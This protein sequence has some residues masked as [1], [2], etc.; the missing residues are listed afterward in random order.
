MQHGLNVEEMKRELQS[1]E[2]EWEALASERPAEGRARARKL[3][4]PQPKSLRLAAAITRRL[5]EGDRPGVTVQW[6]QFCDRVR[7]DLGG[8]ADRKNGRPKRGY[9]QKSIQRAVT[10]LNAQSTE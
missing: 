9:S 1:L 8:W 10:D 4:S 6:K 5:A 3:R 7:D 2:E